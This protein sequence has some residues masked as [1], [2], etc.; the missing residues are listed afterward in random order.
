M[1]VWGWDEIKD[2]VKLQGFVMSHPI[3][4][5]DGDWCFMVAPA[6][7]FRSL[8]TNQSGFTNHDG[9]I[10][11][12]IEPPDDLKGEDSSSA[13]TAIRLLGNPKGQWVTVEGAWVRDKSHD[14]WGNDIGLGGVHDMGKTEIHPVTSILVEHTPPSDNRSRLVEFAVFSDD[15]ANFPANVPHSDEDRHGKF[16]MPIPLGGAFRIVNELN[17]CASKTFAIVPSDR[18]STLECRVASGKASEGKGFYWSFHN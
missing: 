1:G 2:D 16:D 14:V 4:A 5:A 3:V 8:L 18:V 10:E 9:L 12:E 17:M 13:E 7:G 15:S 11:C 6:R